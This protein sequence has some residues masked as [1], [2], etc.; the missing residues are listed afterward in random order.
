MESN[1]DK[2][3]LGRGWSFPPTFSKERADVEMVSKDKDIRQSL[4][5]F[6]NTKYGER[7]MR[8]N[9]GCIVHDYMFEKSDLDV[10]ERLSYELKQTISNYEPRIFVHDV[11]AS[12]S[13][14]QDG[15]ISINISYEV[16]STNVRDNIVFPFYMNEG[17]EIK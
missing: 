3:F 9:Y 17:T 16:H 15:L 7:I 14:T 4:H 6:F 5:I 2:S 8:S 11:R 12:K 1:Q 10:I 13:N